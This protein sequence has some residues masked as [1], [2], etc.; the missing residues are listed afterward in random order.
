MDEQNAQTTRQVEEAVASLSLDKSSE[1]VSSASVTSGS[2]VDVEDKDSGNEKDIG[3]SHEV[4]PC[5]VTSDIQMKFSS[6]DESM[7][8][9]ERRKSASQGSMYTLITAIQH[10]L[11]RRLLKELGPGE[12]AV[13]SWPYPADSCCQKLSV[14]QARA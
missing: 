9:N 13:A 3:S 6:L 12:V 8:K 2:I 5:L 7:E 4:I 11:L 14:V 10:K 1:S